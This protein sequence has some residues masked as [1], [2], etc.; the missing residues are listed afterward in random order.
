[1]DCDLPEAL[2]EEKRLVVRAAVDGLSSVPGVRA[3]ALAGS[4]AR[5]TAR[6][7]SDVDLGIL[8]SEAAPF[9]IAGVRDVARE[10]SADGAP[11]VTGF[12]EWGPWVNGG[13]W[14][15]TSAG[16][17]DFIYRSFE[18]VERTIEEA[19]R[20]IHQHHYNQQPTYGYYSVATLGEI[21]TCVPLFDPAASVTELK[22]RVTSYPRKLRD[23]IVSDYLWAA[24]FTFR[25]AKG[26]AG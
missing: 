25:S 20:G 14:I 18:H 13:A 11:V 19:S 8:Y 16:R 22:K 7:D 2:P 26:F 23:A 4:Y 9:E 1:M 5:G 17:M 12:Y 6:P 21:S 15:H 3:M 10:L 24:E